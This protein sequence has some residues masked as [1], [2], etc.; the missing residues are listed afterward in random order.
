LSFGHYFKDFY[1][2]FLVAVYEVGACW[3]NPAYW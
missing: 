1:A 2:D 3:I